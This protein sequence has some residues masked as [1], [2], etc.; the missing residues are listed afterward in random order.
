MIKEEYYDR[1]DDYYGEVVPAPD[2]GVRILLENV[3]LARVYHGGL[4]PGMRVLCN[5]VRPKRGRMEPVVKIGSLLEQGV[6]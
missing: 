3:C 5:I 6:M 4:K 1:W 2:F